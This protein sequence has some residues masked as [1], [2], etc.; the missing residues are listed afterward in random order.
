MKDL[1][2]WL[3][4]TPQPK[5]ILADEKKIHVPNN[6]R[7]WKDLTQT[8]MALE[9]SK[10]TALDGD[11]N[12]LRSITLE[13]EDEKPAPSPEMTDLQLFAKLLSGAYEKGMTATQPMLNSAMEFVERQGVQLAKAEAEIERLRSHIYKQQL[14]LAEL[15]VGSP[16]GEDDSI[17]GAMLAG[18][19]QGQ[20]NLQ[21]QTT[22]AVTP[23][24]QG[25]KK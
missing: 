21:Q 19:L 4:K 6:A 22:A 16:A 20:A 15:T 25:A 18:A 12:V 17:V 9:P 7:G 23:L 13:S 14:Q 1:T 11:G 24:K 3:R 5:T 10:L 8:I 2:Y